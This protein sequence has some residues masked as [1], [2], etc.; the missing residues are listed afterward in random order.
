MAAYC[1]DNAVRVFGVLI[2]NALE[3]RVNNG[4]KDKPQWEPRYTLQQ[5]L[6]PHFHL[7]EPARAKPVLSDIERGHQMLLEMTKN[8]RSRVKAW[9]TVAPS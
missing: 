8:P 3:E 4:T 2:E 6:S 5:L 7:P 9:H 1:I